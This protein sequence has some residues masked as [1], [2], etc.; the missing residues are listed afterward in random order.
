[1]DGT[2][3]SLNLEWMSHVQHVNI[4]TAISMRSCTINFN[5]ATTAAIS[6]KLTYAEKK[7]KHSKHV[8]LVSH[9]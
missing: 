9:T 4:V 5:S 7:K 3:E 2:D 8:V 1:M 6:T